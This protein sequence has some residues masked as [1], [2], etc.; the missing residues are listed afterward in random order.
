MQ[1]ADLFDEAE[2]AVVLSRTATKNCSRFKMSNGQ[3]FE[4]R[5]FLPAGKGDNAL[6][7]GDKF[8]VFV[9][10]DKSWIEMSETWEKKVDFNLCGQLTQIVFKEIDTPN[11]LEHF[12]S[13]QNLHYRGGG[14]AGRT[15]PII[16]TSNV[17]NLPTV[18]GF[19]EVSSSMIANSARKRFLDFP[20]HEGAN[21]VWKTWNR[22]TAREYSNMICR[23]SR[24]VIHPEIRGLGLARAF[25]EAAMSYAASRW[26]YGGFRPRFMEITADMLRYYHF[27]D[28]N[29][30]FVGETQ[31]NE[32]RLQKDMQYLVRKARSTEEG[33]KGMPQGGGGIMTLQRSYATTLL[34]YT[35]ANNKTLPDVINSL[36]YD[37]SALDQE[38]WEALY[39][40][41]RR[42]KPCY[43]AGITDEARDYVQGRNKTLG[44]KVAANIPATRRSEKEWMLTDITIHTSAKISQ[45][46]DA[47]ILQDSFGFV[48]SKLNATILKPTGFTIRSGEITLVCGASGSGKSLLLDGLK[49]IS[50]AIENK[51]LEVSGDLCTLKYSGRINREA[52]V[53]TI[54]KLPTNRTPLE[55]MGRATLDEFLS[56]TA[57]L[58]LAEPQLFVRQNETL[59]SGQ[60]YRLQVALAFLQRPDILVIDNFCENL[61][62]F[63]ILAV[64][65]G[66][67]HLMSLYNVALIAA[68]AAYDRVQES[69]QADQ[70][71][72]LKR[73]DY[74]TVTERKVSTDHEI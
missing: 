74:A 56:V 3:K 73:G 61:D 29:F 46:K 71:I 22:V 39:K 30:V 47:R 2:T 65:K 37:A 19:I 11:E 26:H 63:T 70:T 69:L 55:L 18:L 53:H 59:S 23:I 45:S 13:L 27:L 36:K 66:I 6:L 7:R 54:K 28:E 72:L 51:E 52:N 12:S 8:W 48:G 60:K 20:Y 33:S 57:Q 17:W 62:R 14:G 43:I 58:G 16:A 25:I 67:K 10:R 68:T 5:R 38:T 34:N 49:R 15:V 35:E 41:N 42:P 31:G 1:N 9:K 21:L 40:L 32:H 4:S 24:F 50:A 64:C 44:L